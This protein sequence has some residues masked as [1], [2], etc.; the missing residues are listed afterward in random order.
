[1]DHAAI[2][3]TANFSSHLSGYLGSFIGTAVAQILNRCQTEVSD[4][5]GKSKCGGKP[6]IKKNNGRIRLL[7][8]VEN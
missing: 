4:A 1:M 3:I 8:A 7:V 6:L 5:A 2:A